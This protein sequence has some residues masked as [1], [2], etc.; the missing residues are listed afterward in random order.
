MFRSI[1][2]LSTIIFL[3]ILISVIAVGQEFRQFKIPIVIRISAL[4]DR[5]DTLWLGVHGDGPNPPGTVIDNTYGPD[6]DLATFGEWKE[7]NY[8]PDPQEFDFISKFIQI[9]G[10]TAL[11]PYGIAGT[12]MKPNDFRGYISSSQVDTFCINVYG[13]GNASQVSNGSITLSWPSGLHNYGTTWIL[14]RRVSGTNYSTVVADMGATGVVSYTDDNVA[15]SN[16]VRYLIIR[17]GSIIPPPQPFHI[18]PTSLDFGNVHENITSGIVSLENSSETDDIVITSITAPSQFIVTPSTPITVAKQGGTSSIT[19]TF[20][21]TSLAAGT[22]AGI[23]ILT[24]NAIYGMSGTTST[25]P[26]SASVV[27][28]GITAAPTT[29]NFGVIPYPQTKTA[30]VT[31]TNVSPLR[32]VRNITVTAPNGFSVTPSTIDSI[33]KGGT[34]NLTVT[35]T[36]LVS[37]GDQSGNVVVTSLNAP[38]INIGVSGV[39][40]VQGGKLLFDAPEISVLDNSYDSEG[41][42]NGGLA[43]EGYYTA[44]IGLHE[45]AGTPLQAIE[46]TLKSSGKVIIHSIEK[47]DRIADW[48]SRV[49]Y[50]RGLIQPDGSSIDT[51]RVV[52]L[53]LKSPLD[54]TGI[55][56]VPIPLIKFGYDVVNISTA[57]DSTSFELTRILGSTNTFIDAKLNTNT[58]EKIIIHN[59]IQRGDINK[60][61]R[62][63]ILDLLAIVD[64]ITGKKPLTGDAFIAA[65]VAPWPN[66]DGVVNVIDL[67][68]LQNIILNNKYPDGNPLLQIASHPVLGSLSKTAA[69]NVIFHVTTDEIGVEIKNTSPFRGLQAKIFGVQS[70]VTSSTADLNGAASRLAG[71]T[72]TILVKQTDGLPAGDHVVARIPIV[73]RTVDIKVGSLLVADVNLQPASYNQSIEN[74][75]A[76]DITDVENE[77]QDLPKE[78]H[79]SQNYPNPFNPETRINFAVPTSSHVHIAVY[80]LLGQEVIT[81]VNNELRA[82]RYHVIF[83]GK[84]SKGQ[85]LASGTYIYRMTAGKFIENRKMLFVK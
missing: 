16:S 18:S 72:L 66:G 61:D 27:D 19:V 49:E 26:V 59:R 28:P 3:L 65:D 50:Y 33:S 55:T 4:P 78:F 85:S 67:A 29:I 41:D 20:D 40:Q 36:T 56:S 43:V 39:S 68:Q 5:V 46:F 34:A 1:R 15:A 80:N 83:S 57:R 52:L 47:S 35:Y 31:L 51:F 10:R 79:L 12:G 13:D 21:A 71:D 17:S 73:C 2:F 22:Y 63:D 7:Y 74:T 24:H 60:D 14:K 54:T 76:P 77:P 44:T 6:I 37:G 8:P 23:I 53:A 69:L 30:T 62:V 64:H 45:Y 84:D 81:L 58:T 11:P 70:A 42:A 75:K 9:P 32:S 82:G 48:F 38:S 25:I